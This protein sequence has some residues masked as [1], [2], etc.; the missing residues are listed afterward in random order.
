MKA[1]AFEESAADALVN[2]AEVPDSIWT[3]KEATIQDPSIRF[4]VTGDCF[5]AIGPRAT[6][7]SRLIIFPLDESGYFNGV[8]VEMR[9]AVLQRCLRAA[10]T[11]LQPGSYLPVSWAAYHDREYIIFYCTTI[12][13]RRTGYSARSVL[14][15][16]LGATQHVLFCSYVP[17]DTSFDLRNFETPEYAEQ[18]LEITS[19]AFPQALSR[20][21]VSAN[22]HD[23]ERVATHALATNGFQ[24][25]DWL[26]L[27]TSEQSRFVLSEVSGP[28]KLR[29]A[30]GTGKTLALMLKAL[31][32]LYAA[33]DESRPWRCA[34][35]T[36]NW[37]SAESTRQSLAAMDSRGLFGIPNAAQSILVTTLHTMAIAALHLNESNVLPISE[38]GHEGKMMQVE[39]IESL[40]T[41]F[42][43]GDWCLYESRCSATFRSRLG[44]GAESR[45]FAWDL[46]N[47]FA[48]V[49]S[50]DRRMTVDSYLAIERRQ[51]MMKLTNRADREVVFLLHERFRV[52]MHEEI[53][54]LTTYDVTN[55]YLRVLET[56]SW[57]FSRRKLGLDLLLVDEFHLFNK[58][59][60]LAFHSLSR[61]PRQAPRVV[62]A[63]DPRQSP[64]DTFLGFKA[65]PKHPT[66]RALEQPTVKTVKLE[67]VFRYTAEVNALIQ[68]L[69]TFWFTFA[70]DDE[71]NLPARRA[72]TTGRIP[73]LVHVVDFS[74]AID[75]AF[76][77]A[78]DFVTE[79]GRGAT[80]AILCLDSKHF[81]KTLQ[82]IKML[83][84][85]R[86]C[87]VI[88]SRDSTDGLLALG[89]KYVISQPEYVAG[90]QFD[91]VIIPDAQDSLVAEGTENS[92]QLRRLLSSLYLAISRA[93]R[94]VKIFAS[95]SE[96]GAIRFLRPAVAN[97]YLTECKK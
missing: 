82:R 65:A 58:H 46:M 6:K 71:H 7:T 40:V 19:K 5:F 1:I 74:R 31:R 70:L 42:R 21:P 73:Q 87:R 25:S 10:L 2:A 72:N 85:E 47:E 81:E 64:L 96:G 84:R 48:C 55:D 95:E 18:A 24:Y 22:E 92:L 89:K 59:E 80:V 94:E 14:K 76:K 78:R 51:W 77:A 41:E 11:V 86:E 90:L 27:L 28:T 32:E 33:C 67:H 12:A 97:G 66:N 4:I 54:A 83:G 29:G 26:A 23:L 30:A 39:A 38:D 91:C 44:S 16:H 56:N 88:A 49:V 63:M 61:D 79:G 57:E 45:Q 3:F 20:S 35:I 52:L 68:S 15:R 50:A 13:M 37:I 60:L 93:K 43:N 36:H 53:G 34:I 17:N 75:E 62:V 69:E 9:Q 8:P